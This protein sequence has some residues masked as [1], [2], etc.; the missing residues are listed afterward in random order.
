MNEKFL[1]EKLDFYKEE[2]FL[3]DFPEIIEKGLSENILLREYQKDAFQ[4]FVTY[5]EKDTLR[6]NKQL[7]TLFHMA[8]GSGKTVIIAGLILYLY[9]KG[10]NNFLF[11]VNQTNIIEKTKDNFF[12]KFSTKYL[13]NKNIEYLGQKIKINMVDSFENSL[14]SNQD[15]NICFTTTQKL[16][17]DLFESKENS[18]TYTT[19]EDNKVVFISDESHHINSSTKKLNKTEENEKKTWEDSIMKAFCSNKDSI[20]LEFTATVD[21]RNKNIEEKYKEKI[22]FNYP[23]KNFRESCY[24]KEFQNISTDTNLW[25][26]TLIAVILSEYRKYLFTDLKLNIKPVLMLKSSKIGDSKNFYEEF[27]E[28][29]KTL[30]ITEL[31][32]ISNET[33]IDVLKRAFEYFIKKD[34]SFNFLLHSIKDSFSENN[35]ILVNGKEDLKKETQL[36]I[37]S[38]EDIDNPIRVIFAVDMLNE[39]WD[40]L[41]LFDIVRLYDTRQGS[42]ES[43]KVG[44]YT[45]KEAQL[46]GRGARYC[47]FQINDEQEKYK[48]KYDSDLENEYRILETMYFHSK[49]DSKY[50]S[51]LRQALIEL[52]IQ[53]NNNEKIKLEYKLKDSFKETDFYKNSKLYINE[54]IEKDRSKIFSIKENI[55]NKVFLYRVNTFEGRKLNLFNGNNENLSLE[56]KEDPLNSKNKKLSDI[57]YH[58]LLGASECFSELKFNILKEKFP[59]LKSVKE[60]LTSSNY[61]GNIEIEF[62]FKNP[63]YTLKGRDY[64]NALKIV[65]NDISKYIISIKPEYEGTK[66][67]IPKEINKIIKDKKIYISKEI[68][69]GGKGES[70]IYTSND[71]LKLDLEKESWYVFNDNYGTS[72]EKAFIKYFKTNIIPKLN[73]KELEYYVIR[74]ERELAIYSFNDGAR[75]E[76]DYLLFIRKKKIDKDY[77]DYQIFVE[78]KGEHLLET[79]SWKEKFLKDIKK[80]AKLK[81]DKS[82][83]EELIENKNYFVLGLPFFNKNFRKEDFDEAINKFLKEI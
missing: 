13:F 39:G 78:P 27:L 11:F 79:D 6:K 33:N 7:H 60:F 44:A 26:R 18:L 22:I 35:L 15:I 30:N 58:I 17:L 41:N 66:V 32:K 71:N 9:T 77:I 3:K 31:E 70:Q 4:Y 63:L 8:T 51:E 38:L 82:K 29:I 49:N 14:S 59:N 1:Y 21:L 10:Y 80:E 24:T 65:F 81:R 52:G 16:H 69:N 46:I 64:F 83:N 57:E 61:L 12:N 62:K 75:F 47:P 34:K 19:F 76:P 45:I 48:R 40:V 74:N 72:E 20:L 50:I 56:I 55:K 5:F 67:F 23:L 68:E 2:N 53:D 43:G 73:E 36:A 42:G 25:E 37:N 54:R 28:K